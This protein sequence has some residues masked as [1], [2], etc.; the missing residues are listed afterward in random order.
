MSTTTIQAPELSTET[1]KSNSSQHKEPLQLQG[2][3]DQFESFDVTPIIGKEFP[4]ANLKDWL[5]APH[6]DELLKDLAITG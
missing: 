4:T 6:S 2:T 3:L 1:V 5:E